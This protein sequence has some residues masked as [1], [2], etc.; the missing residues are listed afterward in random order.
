MNFGSHSP[1]TRLLLANHESR[2]NHLRQK[3][4]R[5]QRQAPI[6]RVPTQ[7]LTSITSP[8]P[9]AQ[10]GID[11]V[12]PLP[13]TPAQEKLLL[14]ATNYFIYWIKDEAFTSIKD[15][16]VI[17]FVWKNIVYRFKTPQSIIIDNGP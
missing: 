5:C 10:W 4:H 9:F 7:D 14:V 17:Q 6:S 13:T 12:R 16:D 1:Y 2:C 11:I 15:K 8:W 3:V